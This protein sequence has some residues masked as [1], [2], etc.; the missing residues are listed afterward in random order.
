MLELEQL[1]Q[2]FWANKTT[3]AENTR[4]IQLLEQYKETMKN[5]MQN[6]F[7]ERLADRENDLPPDKA[8][9]ILQK[10]HSNLDITDLMGGFNFRE[11]LFRYLPT[12]GTD[13]LRRLVRR[14]A[15]AAAIALLA[16]SAFLLIGRPRD[17]RPIVKASAPATP[18]LIRLVNNADSILPVTLE[19]GSTVQLG[20]NSSLTWY[21]PF[22]NHR[23]DLSLRG[24]ALFK[25][26]KEKTRP[27]TVYAGGIATTAL[28]TRFWVNATD[29]KKIRVRLL[30]GRVMVNAAAGS[31]M[32]MSDVFLAPGQE[33]SFNRNSRRYTVNAADA[34]P[35]NAGKSVRP[36]NKPEL[37]F[38]KEPLGLVFEKVGYLYK[39]PLAFRMEDLDGLYFTGTFLK[40]DS[41]NTVLST[42]CNVNDL[43]VTKEGD[44]IIIAKSH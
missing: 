4:L 39:V 22:I 42:I 34:K 15:V 14:I 24:V 16:G 27:F 26:A 3:L 8:L 17:D 7:Q 30:E 21:K 33:L 37:V 18:R 36:A 12:G 1:I 19:D 2:K 35:D 29:G 5:S 28:G 40:S 9:S 41:L 38:R 13:T 10:I 20:K 43:L 11:G 31:G 32:A 25:V 44:R 6:E 23:R